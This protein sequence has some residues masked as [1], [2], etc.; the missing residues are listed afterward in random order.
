[1]NSVQA[2][3]AET[4]GKAVAQLREIQIP[5]E[6]ILQLENLIK[7][8]DEPCVVAVVGRVKAGK[9]TFINVLLEADLAPVGVTETTATI[10]YF[11]AGQPDHPDFPVRCKWRG[12]D[13]LEPQSFAFLK[14][15][16]GNDIE[17]LRRAEKIEYLEYLLPRAFLQ[18]VTLVDTPGIASVVEDHQNVTAEYIRLFGQLRGPYQQETRRLDSSVD[19]VIY[20]FGYLPGETDQ[21]FLNEFAALTGG[22]SQATNAIGVM[23]KIDLQSDF[24]E[25]AVAR[26]TKYGALLK[27]QLHT[28]IPVSAGLQ[29]ALDQLRDN[30]WAG[31]SKIMETLHRIDDPK[32]LAQLL[33]SSEFYTEDESLVPVTERKE[34]LGTFDWTVFKTIVTE[35]EAAGWDLP[36]T[37][38]RLTKLAGF[39]PLRTLLQQHFYAQSQLIRSYRILNDALKIVREI[40]FEF[41]RTLREKDGEKKARLTQFLAFLRQVK[42]SHTDEAHVRQELIEFVITHS[43]STGQTE[44][45]EKV[46][47]QVER[48]ISKAHHNVKVMAE[49]IKAL[50]LLHDHAHLFSDAQELAELQALFGRNGMGREHRLLPEHMEASYIHDRVQYWRGIHMQGKPL[51]SL[52]AEYATFCYGRLLDEIGR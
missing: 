30:H 48:A 49:D 35:A 36:T 18:Q 12:C 13:L 10:N 34:L 5:N 50:Q 2:T 42:S 40:R 41:L 8:L 51:M 44:Q 26:A 11:R 16:Q 27:N 25:R 6:H 28:I 4:L 17:T 3:L 46:F 15:L 24:S 21:R 45:A 43:T 38:E 20:L 7:Q 47:T 19:A 23:A 39:G 29:R 31:L 22:K 52:I 33:E 32:S 14:S 37:V 1:M 9:S